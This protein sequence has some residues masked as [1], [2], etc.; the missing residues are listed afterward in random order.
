MKS[1]VR[2]GDNLALICIVGNR[3]S[4]KSD[5]QIRID[6]EDVCLDPCA[7]TADHSCLTITERSFLSS[8]V[9][10]QRLLISVCDNK[11]DEIEEVVIQFRIIGNLGFSL[12]KLADQLSSGDACAFS[13][14]I[15]KMLCHMF[16]DPPL[17]K[18]GC[19]RLVSCCCDFLAGCDQFFGGLRECFYSGFR[20]DIFVINDTK[21]VA[22]DRKAVAAGT[23]CGRFHC[24]CYT[25]IHGV[26]QG[27]AGQVIGIFLIG[28]DLLAGCG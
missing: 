28:I 8:K 14:G 12:L 9:G 23:V 16:E 1:L 21:E 18:T 7:L 13:C 4:V 26:N 19:E 25:G 6:R 11:I 5:I 22:L 2:T 27:L 17:S 20:K 3:I 24:R 10:L 15:D